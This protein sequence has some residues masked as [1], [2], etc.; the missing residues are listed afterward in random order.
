MAQDFPPVDPDVDPQHPEIHNAMMKLLLDKI[1]EKPLGLVVVS[2]V[3]STI[4]AVQTLRIRWIQKRFRVF[5]PKGDVRKPDWI[6]LLLYFV[7]ASLVTGTIALLLLKERRHRVALLP[8]VF[9]M[10]ASVI[11]VCLSV[12]IDRV[13]RVVDSI[14]D[15]TTEDLKD[16]T[17][18]RCLFVHGIA[19]IVF[20]FACYTCYSHSQGHMNT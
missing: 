19:G 3:V 14:E 18:S 4:V 10:V 20:A 9:G 8:F 13:L 15:S 17:V 16:Q 1:L 5:E 2:I 6:Y 12:A 7:S 11:G